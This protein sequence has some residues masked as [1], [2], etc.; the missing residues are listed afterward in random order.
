[1]AQSEDKV[2]D[3]PVSRAEHDAMQKQLQAIEA[4]LKDKQESDKQRAT[5]ELEGVAQA[6]IN[7]AKESGAI[8]GDDTEAEKW[9]KK[10]AETDL[11]LAK[12]TVERLSK[13]KKAEKKEINFGEDIKDRIKQIS[14]SNAIR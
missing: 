2:K 1:M 3:A 11:K 7:T 12:E 8:G 14:R 4:Q 10:L 5:A 6:L 9:I 13:S